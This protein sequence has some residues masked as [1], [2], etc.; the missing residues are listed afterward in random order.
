MSLAPAPS[1][2]P[3]TAPADLRAF[4]TLLSLAWLFGANHVAARVAF[5][6]GVDVVTAVAVRSLATA[7]VVALIVRALALP[8][9]LAARQWRWLAAVGAL[10]AVQSLCLY[11]AVARLPVALALLAFNSFPMWVALWSMLVYRQRPA[12]AVL[13]AMPVILIGLAL[14]L[15]V[16]GAAAHAAP[17]GFGVGVSFALAAAASFGLALVLTQHELASVEGR[18]RTMLTMALVG[19]LALVLG[20]AGTGLH[21]PSGPGAAAGW[22][23]LALLTLFYGTGFTVMFVLL[24]RLG[25]AANSPILNTEPVAALA[26]AWLLLDQALAPVQLLGCAVVV[27]A[28]MALGLRR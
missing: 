16:S 20:L 19:G 12:R 21:W 2:R 4:V 24:P 26:M 5:D 3:P 28:V 17:A 1:P 7:L 6:H 10:I 27:A 15:D 14:A 13:W 18:V 8:V 25:V 23:G 22:A 9:R 11:A